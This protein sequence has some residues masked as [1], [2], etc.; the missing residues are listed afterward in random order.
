MKDLW[1]KAAAAAAIF[2]CA[3]S[4]APAITVNFD[5]GDADTGSVFY[6]GSLTGSLQGTGLAFSDLVVDG[7][8]YACGSPCMANFE[9][10]ALVGR[11]G[12]IYQF[13]A[14]GFLT[15]E[16]AVTIGPNSAS[17]V[18]VSGQFS[19]AVNVIVSANGSELSIVGFGDFAAS[20]AFQTVLGG[21]F[22]D[23]R[24]IATVISDSAANGGNI[25]PL[26]DPVTGAFVAAIVSEADIRGS[27]SAIPLPASAAL[28]LAGL[29]GLAL[30]ARRRALA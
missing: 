17:G 13:A 10:G 15:I 21:L 29:A 7:V 8:H 16:G 1:T 6:D 11:L 9:T 25:Q 4:A 24:F 30:A 28:M 18:L 14:G 23:F 5:N 26:V 3:A 19:E 2:V 12:N 22:S 27:A 20:P